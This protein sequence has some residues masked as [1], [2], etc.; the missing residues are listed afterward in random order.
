MLFF[1]LGLAYTQQSSNMQAIVAGQTRYGPRAVR[2]CLLSKQAAEAIMHS[3][4]EEGV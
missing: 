1:F 3:A 2:D 4:K